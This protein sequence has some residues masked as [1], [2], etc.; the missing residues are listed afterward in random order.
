MSESLGLFGNDLVVGVDEDHL[1][2]M[3][4]EFFFCQGHETG[5]NDD[6]ALLG[7]VSRSPVDADGGRAAWGRQGIG[8]EAVAVGDVPNMDVFMR[9][10]IRSLEQIEV[11]RNAAFVMQVGVGDRGSMNF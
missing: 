9:K 3:A 5:D 6:I 2:L 11:D 8:F 1:G 7:Q 10:D 4:G